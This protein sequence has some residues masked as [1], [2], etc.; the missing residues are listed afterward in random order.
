MYFFQKKVSSNRTQT[1]I[2]R[3]SRMLIKKKKHLHHRNKVHLNVAAISLALMAISIRLKK[4]ITSI[5]VFVTDRVHL[6][7]QCST[8]LRGKTLSPSRSSTTTPKILTLSFLVTKNS[9]LDRGTL[10]PD[11]EKAVD[12]SHSGEEKKN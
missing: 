2:S 10:F 5:T 8:S 7:R 3:P 1:V 9:S 6:G 4:C 12:L 11:N